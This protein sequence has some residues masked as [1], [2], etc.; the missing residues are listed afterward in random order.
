[1]VISDEATQRLDTLERLA[2]DMVNFANTAGTNANKKSQEKKYFEFCQWLEL[3]PFPA[4]EWRLVLYATYLS[5]TMESID[6]IKSYCGLVC[7]LQEMQGAEPIRRGKIYTKAI[8]G[9][10]RLLQ[11][12]TKW[13]QPV[14]IE[15]LEQMSQYINVL[16]QKQVA[17]W[18]AILFGFFLFLRKSNL[19]L[20]SRQHDHLHQLS[21]ADISYDDEVLIAEIKWSKMNQFGEKIL[22]IPII[23]DRQSPVCPVGWL[24]FMVE[25]IPAAPMHNLFSYQDTQGHLVPV[26]YVDLTLELR[27]LLTQIGVNNVHNFSS[28]SLRRGGTCHAFA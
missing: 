23:R 1:M 5:L 17:T 19:V 25:S 18:V 27:Y 20:V 22:P 6:S 21:R 8:Q 28:H 15:M 7:E 16:D 13:A 3:D 9:I 12:E 2:R 24:L 14:T 11:H 10:R 26:T 4:N